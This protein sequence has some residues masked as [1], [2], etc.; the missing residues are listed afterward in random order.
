MGAALAGCSA[1]AH[2]LVGDWDVEAKNE[3]TGD[4]LYYTIFVQGEHDV[5]EHFEGDETGLLVNFDVDA[6]GTFAADVQFDDPKTGTFDDGTSYEMTGTFD[7][8]GA[9]SEVERWDGKWTWT[10]KPAEDDLEDKKTTTRA[11]GKSKNKDG[12]F[13]WKSSFKWNNYEKKENGCLLRAYLSGHKACQYKVRDQ[14]YEYDFKKM[15]QINA[16][17]GRKRKI[18]PPYKLKAPTEPIVPPGPATVVKVPKG[19]PGNQIHVP[20]PQDETKFIAVDVPAHAKVGSVMLVPVP[21]L[22]DPEDPPKGDEGEDKKKKKKKEDKTKLSGAEKAGF[23]AG[24]AALIGG[25]AVAGA[26]IGDAAQDGA[27]DGVGDAVADAA[28]DAGDAAGDLGGVI[29]DA[30]DDIDLDDAGD[31]LMDLGEDTGDLITDLF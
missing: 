22:P 9:K 27:F 6:A 17:S 8:K 21:P 28:G 25:A 23:A 7:A 10:W 26:I 29:M 1:K 15:V 20:H 2:G 14:H 3:K 24:G 4:C 5:E 13:Q 16:D 12:S 30:V 31:F 19:G 18:R 11:F